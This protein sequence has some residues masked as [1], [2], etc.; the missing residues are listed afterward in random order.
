MR[1]VSL[2]V[3]V[4]GVLLLAGSI[5]SAQA[6]AWDWTLHPPVDRAADPGDSIVWDFTVTN[7]TV[8][9]SLSI[10]GF[11]ASVPQPIF[12]HETQLWQWSD[13]ANI[14]P[15]TSYTGPFVRWEWDTTA[16]VGYSTSGTYRLAA[17]T[18][19]PLEWKY[20]PAS[21]TVTPEPATC[22]LLLATGVPLAISRLRRRKA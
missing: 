6:P 5:A 13:V 16:P 1:S 21:A 8:T 10:I 9:P 14:L 18:G 15:G 3:L 22:V 2:V 11:G 20:E 17:P 19:S 12:A 4:V 7:N